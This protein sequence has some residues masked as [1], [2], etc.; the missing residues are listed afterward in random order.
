MIV[1][2]FKNYKKGKEVVE[3]ARKIQKYL[4]KAVVCVPALDIKEVVR[5]AKLTVYAQ[6]VSCFYKGKSTG[7][8]VPEFVRYDGGAGSLLNHSA[9]RISEEMVVKTMK[10]ARKARLKIILC[11]SSLKE[12]KKFKKLKPYAMAYEDK[13]LIGTGKSITKYKS[14]DVSR[15]AELLKGTGIISLCG[16]GVSSVEDVKAARKLGCKGVLISSAVANSRSPER[17]L[18]K[19]SQMY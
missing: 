15:F 3:L 10:V 5:K 12:A 18:N 9:H 14:K 11:V 2:N 17:L 1:I 6:H 8:V 4:S 7:Y 13:K 19:L 16:A